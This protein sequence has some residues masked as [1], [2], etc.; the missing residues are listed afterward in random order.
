M[1]YH[2]EYCHCPKELWSRTLTTYN[3]D[4]CRLYDSFL[5]LVQ[6]GMTPEELA[7]VAYAELPKEFPD[8]TDISATVAE[9]VQIVVDCGV[10][11][12]QTTAARKS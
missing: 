1:E 4:E 6:D 5:S 8:I 11:T 12:R 7:K 9:L 10:V 3:G 2:C